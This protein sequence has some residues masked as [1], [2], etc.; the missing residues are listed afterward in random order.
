MFN[1]LKHAS[2]RTAL[3]AATLFATATG[4]FA[5]APTE[6]QK[7]AIR[8]ACRSDFMAHCSSVTPG[9]VEA[10]QCLAKN[11]SSLSSGC[12][13]A[14]RAVE[15]AAA[16]KTE[17]APAKSEP[18]KTEAEPAAKPAAAAA[19]KAA[20]PKQPSS[21]QVSAIKSACRGDYPKVCA[22]VPPGGAPALE[23][24]EKNKAKVSAGCAKAVNAASGGG[25][26]AAAPAAGAAPAAAA[27]PAAA[28]AVIVLRPL[29]PREEL[30]IV[31]SACGAD[32]RTLCAGVAPGGGRII[33]CISNNA[34]SLSPACKD[35]LAPFA[36]R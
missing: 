6:A 28:P 3:L 33:Q 35:V 1:T 27:T 19:S 36:A 32:I 12:Q 20:A 17:A 18:A 15:P 16:P 24:L 9:G 11:M 10:F 23:C 22:G 34:A 26:A 29:L 5:Q 7:S 8:S 13:A 25:T 14:V 4:A 21:A 30:F 2:T 31:R